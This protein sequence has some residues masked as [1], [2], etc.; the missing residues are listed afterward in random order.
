V[1]NIRYPLWILLA[2]FVLAVGCITPKPKIDP[3]EGWKFS[4]ITNFESNTIV[5]N[6]CE[7]YVKQLSPDEQKFLGPSPFKYY[8]DETGQHA[9]T[10][11]IGID[12]KVWRHVL[13]Y[14]K[15]G[16]RVKA[17]KYV[18]GDYRS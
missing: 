14:D 3:L 7:S 5:R 18:S 4:N 12:G 9:V 1:K 13:I 16:K 6:D 8:E 15:D 10:I 17:I 2:S 11:T